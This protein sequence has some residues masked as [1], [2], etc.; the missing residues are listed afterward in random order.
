MKYN[1]DNQETYTSVFPFMFNLYN[2]KIKGVI[3]EGESY[4]YSNG[5]WSDAADLKQSLIDQAYQYCTDTPK[6]APLLAMTFDGKSGFNV[7]NYP[8]KAISVPAS[9]HTDQCNGNHNWDEGTITLSPTCTE[10]GIKEFTCTVCGATRTETIP[11]TG[12]QW[13]NWVSIID[14]ET[15]E[16]IRERMCT[17]CAETERISVPEGGTDPSTNPTENSTGNTSG[18]P[19]GNTT[20]NTTNNSTTGNNNSTNTLSGNSDSSSNAP[21]TGDV[22]YLMILTALLLSGFSGVSAGR[23]LLKRRSRKR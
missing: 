14:V 21:E 15:S 1:K 17:I 20:G 2:T 6:F 12:H 3:N 11:A 23:M 4:F 16:E 18:T 13:G 19:E 10:N 8:I 9:L 22:N 5:N 7:D